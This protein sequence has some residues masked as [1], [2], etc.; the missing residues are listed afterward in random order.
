MLA[1]LTLFVGS[2]CNATLGIEERDFDPTLDLSDT[3]GSATDTS[4][5]TAVD[6]DDP[7]DTLSGNDTGA[8]V[9]TTP[10]TRVT[11]DTGVTPTDTG[12]PTLDTG[13]TGGGDTAVS[14]TPI[15]IDTSIDSGPDATST[16]VIFVTSVT[17]TGNLGGLS[18][19]DA[20][21]Q[22]L[23]TAAGL[24]GTYKA[25]LSDEATSASSRLTHSTLPYVLVSG[26]TV[27]K[28]WTQL[29]SG[30]L[31]HAIDRTELGG[32]PPA[33]TTIEC[34]GASSVFTGTDPDG[35]STLS[36][37][38]CGGWTSVSVAEEA[39]IGDY[40]STGSNWTRRCSRPVCSAFLALYCLQQ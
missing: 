4:S 26:S 10:D 3:A 24:P 15:V 27:A 17:Y 22:G 6:S 14:D 30:L 23:A 31:A 32:T 11:A 38:G 18:G 37:T 19:A 13:G 1:V 5:D 20:K 39:Q 40:K 16:R 12:T 7:K 8:A 2:A 29:T 35:F 25:W 34:T 28:N 33:S 36:T 21:C 9:D